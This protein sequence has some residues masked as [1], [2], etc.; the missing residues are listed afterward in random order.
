MITQ[1]LLTP[2]FLESLNGGS[3]FDLDALKVPLHLTT[4]QTGF[5]LPILKVHDF[6]FHRTLTLEDFPS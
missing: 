5:F 2:D 6:P 1:G 4:L 3:P